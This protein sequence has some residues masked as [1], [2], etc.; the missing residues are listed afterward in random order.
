MTGLGTKEVIKTEFIDNKC[1][2]I[3]PIYVSKDDSLTDE[4][5]DSILENN[6]RWKTF[7][8]R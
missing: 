5:V 4:T 7:C 2:L 6:L 3:K 8:D 1:D